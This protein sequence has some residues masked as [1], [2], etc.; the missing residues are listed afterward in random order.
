MLLH[1]AAMQT[2]QFAMTFEPVV[3]GT[4]L[5]ADAYALMTRPAE[6]GDQ[7]F[8]HGGGVARLHAECIARF[9]GQ[10]RIERDFEMAHVLRALPRGDALVHDQLGRVR[11]FLVPGGVGSSG[12]CGRN[13]RCRVRGLQRTHLFARLHEPRCGYRRDIDIGLAAREQ[14]LRAQCFET[15]VE[16]SAH[17]VELRIAG[18]TEA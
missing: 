14:P 15:R 1:E 17:G 2:R 6:P 10:A 16:D 5:V 3:R 7:A 13:D 11:L 8:D 4:D 18:I 12:D 9:V